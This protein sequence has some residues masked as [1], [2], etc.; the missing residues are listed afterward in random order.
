MSFFWAPFVDFL[1]GDFVECECDVDEGIFSEAEGD[2][3][4]AFVSFF[5]FC[6]FLGV[7]SVAFKGVFRGDFVGVL[8]AI[9]IDCSLRFEVVSLRNNQEIFDRGVWIWK[10]GQSNF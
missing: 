10:T 8:F 5:A 6:D 2:N 3:V 1:G 9:A 4:D 7:S